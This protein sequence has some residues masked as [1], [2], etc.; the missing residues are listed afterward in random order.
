MIERVRAVHAWGIL[1]KQASTDH[2]KLTMPQFDRL[3]DKV[4][5]T[6]RNFVKIGVIGASASVA[7]LHRSKRAIAASEYDTDDGHPSF[8]HPC[9]LK[10]MRVRTIDGDR[11]IQDLRIGDHIPAVF[12]GTRQIKSI[13]SHSYEKSDPSQPWD[14]RVLPVHIAPSALAPGV[15]HADLYL[16]RGHSMLIDDMLFPAGSL[17]NGTT[18]TWYGAHEFEK[19]EFFHI[20]FES[21]DAFYVEGTPCESLL[22]SDAEA[23]GILENFDY[24]KSPL[25]P[26]PTCAPLAFNGGRSELTSCLRSMLSPWLDYRCKADIVRD[27]LDELAAQQGRAQCAVGSSASSF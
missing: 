21:H 8:S 15:P 18:I 5:R 27:R 12:G 23:E 11:E 20:M 3:S 4:R 22:T 26:S 17:I 10:G 25:I 19:L 1:Q 14:R 2:G 13:S 6:R 16:T 24:F 9:I 7:A